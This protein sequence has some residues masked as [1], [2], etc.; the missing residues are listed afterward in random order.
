MF[1]LI[2]KFY[3]IDEVYRPGELSFQY[4]Q[5]VQKRAA[6]VAVFFGWLPAVRSGAVWQYTSAQKKRYDRLAKEHG[7]N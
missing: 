5:R 4:M 6:N 1:W 7:Q 3:L 2:K